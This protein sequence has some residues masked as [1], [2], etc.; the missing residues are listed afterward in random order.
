[1]LKIIKHCRES[2]PNDVTGQ[3]LGL[4]EKGILEVTNCFPFPADCDEN[5]SGKWIGEVSVQKGSR[6]IYRYSTI[7]TRHDAMLTCSKR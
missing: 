6:L 7:S 2:F 5:A 4:D 3:L 1:M